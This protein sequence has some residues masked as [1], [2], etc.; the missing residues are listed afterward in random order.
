MTEI[1]GWAKGIQYSVR[2]EI[3]PSGGSNQSAQQLVEQ[4][5]VS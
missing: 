5:L 1:L 3:D 4:V 2:H